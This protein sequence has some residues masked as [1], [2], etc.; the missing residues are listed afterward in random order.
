M[1]EKKTLTYEEYLLGQKTAADNLAKM[2]LTEAQGQAQKQYESAISE[3]DKRFAQHMNPY[4][5]SQQKIADMGLSGSGYA[6]YLNDRAYIANITERQAASAERSEADRLAKYDYDVALAGAQADYESKYGAWLLEQEKQKKLEDEQNKLLQSEYAN[7]LLGLSSSEA[8][9]LAKTLVDIGNLDTES[10]YYKSI[11]KSAFKDV[12]HKIAEGTA[13]VN[14][15]GT[16]MTKAEADEYIEDIKKYAPEYAASAKSAYDKSFTVKTA[17]GFGDPS[18]Y[19]LGV[20]AKEFVSAGTGEKIKVWYGGNKY[21]VNKGNKVTSAAVLNAAASNNFDKNAATVF[22]LNGNLYVAYGGDV[23]AVEQ[24]KE[25]DYNKLY[26]FVFNDQQRKSKQPVDITKI[27]PHV[28][29]K[30]R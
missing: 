30:H 19:Q 2:K 6:K 21:K 7:Q 3:A 20:D 16:Q 27:N 28:N 25:S 8:S 17:K 15:D 23:Y 1:D 18:Q 10:E 9:S 12:A 29:R 14:A 24:R 5:S 13:F 11:M 26:D 4:G 22:G